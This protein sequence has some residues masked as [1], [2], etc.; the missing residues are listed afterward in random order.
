MIWPW[1][2]NLTAL[3]SRLSKTWR[4]RVSSA[5]M[6]VGQVGGGSNV[7]A[8][9]LGLGAGADDVRDAVQ[10]SWAGAGG[11]SEV[12][13]AGLD[14]GEVEDVV[15]QRE[16]VLAALLDDGQAAVDVGLR[17]PALEDLGIAQGCR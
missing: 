7:K 15:D 5:W 9:L 11:G 6:L 3:P 12:E 16:Q 8:E 4:S 14:L 13:L 2:V 1:S 10:E 17:R